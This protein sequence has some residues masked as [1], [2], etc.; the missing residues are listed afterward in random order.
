VVVAG[1][2]DPVVVLGAEGDRVGEVGLPALGPGLSVVELAPGVGAF[3]AGRCASGA[4]E[5]FGRPPFR[6]LRSERSER[7]ETTF[8]LASVV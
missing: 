5:A 4:F 2:V 8:E 6:W 1:V 7:L 3:A